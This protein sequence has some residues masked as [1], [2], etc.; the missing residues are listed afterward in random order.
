[1]VNKDPDCDSTPREDA[2]GRFLLFAIPF[3]IAASTATVSIAYWAAPDRHLTSVGYATWAGI[4]FPVYFVLSGQNTVE[5]C[6]LLAILG[7]IIV[8]MSRFMPSNILYPAITAIVAPW[9]MTRIHRR[10]CDKRPWIE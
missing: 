3:G 5:G 10:Y 7:V 2:F 8:V 4:P 1:M 6:V 9:L